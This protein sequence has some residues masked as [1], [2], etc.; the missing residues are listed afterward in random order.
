MLDEVGADAFQKDVKS[1]R[2]R[3]N[4]IKYFRESLFQKDVKSIR[5]RPQ[6]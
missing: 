4:F 6:Y 3:P 1:I 5:L 2:L